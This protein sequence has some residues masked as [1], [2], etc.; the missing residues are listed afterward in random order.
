MTTT[1]QGWAETA[2][3]AAGSRRQAAAILAVLSGVIALGM[4]LWMLGYAALTP[5]LAEA[6]GAFNIP[7]VHG[8]IAIA[9]GFAAVWQ[10]SVFARFRPQLSSAWAVAAG[11]VAVPL[12]Y[13]LAIAVLSVGWE[14]VRIPQLIEAGSG[15]L[16]QRIMALFGQPFG[17][18]MLG[19][20]YATYFVGILH[21]PLSIAAC[22]FAS[23]WA[24]RG[25]RGPSGASM[26]RA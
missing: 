10:W 17:A 16:F 4:S 18:A 5:A 9:G 19:G 14:I 15:N 26:P 22:V 3:P 12:T 24:R 11:I 13:I 2:L 8:V 6:L 23:W 25:L 7:V 1:A 21:I 20:A